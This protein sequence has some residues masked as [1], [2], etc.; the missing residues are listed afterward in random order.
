MFTCWP[1]KTRGE[2]QFTALLHREGNGRGG[3][4]SGMTGT[5]AGKAEREMVQRILPGMPEATH[6]LGNTLVYMPACPDL[7]GIRV[8]RLGM[9]LAEIRGKHPVPD[10]AAAYCAAAQMQRTE[11]SPEYALRYLAGEEVPGAETGWTVVCCQG[12]PMG[13]GKGCGGMIRNHYPKG[14]RNRRLTI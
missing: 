13:W 1:H 11:L 7:K 3:I 6:I 14:L 5:A 10:H 2:G 4:P 8:F 9:H 12:M